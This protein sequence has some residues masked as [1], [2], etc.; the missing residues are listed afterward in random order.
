[1]FGALC[2]KGQPGVLAPPFLFLLSTDDRCPLCPGGIGHPL[3][4]LL[5]LPGAH[6]GNAGCLL[7]AD[8][9][10]QFRSRPRHGP[11]GQC[12][13]GWALRGARCWLRRHRWPNFS[14]PGENRATFSF[15]PFK[16]AT[17]NTRCWSDGEI[18]SRV[19]FERRC[20]GLIS[21]DNADQQTVLN[22]PS[23]KSRLR[24]NLN[25]QLT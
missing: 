2:S 11:D 3:H 13:R 7:C 4:T 18:L 25:T 22:L 9:C 10:L 6:R 12:E 17:I 23:H 19:A 21:L 20:G 15:L 1:M 16:Q 8:A 24:A 14:M 5:F